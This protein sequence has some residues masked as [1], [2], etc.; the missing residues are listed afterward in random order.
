M[1]QCK[2]KSLRILPTQK[3]TGR[4]PVVYLFIGFLSGAIFGGSAVYLWSVQQPTQLQ[5]TQEESN[6]S[7][8]NAS[9]SES[10]SATS[11]SQDNGNDH[12][13]QPKDSELSKIFQHDSQQAQALN[14]E[15]TTIKNTSHTRLH[16]KEER[17]QHN[18]TVAFPMVTPSEEKA[19]S[20]T[21]VTTDNTPQASLHIAVTHSPFEVKENQ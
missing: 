15:H 16:H 19:T 11:T 5:V 12:I 3:K 17:T 10:G 20:P 9:S 2:P 21:D 6:S 18:T 13:L 8:A 4:K 14:T 1:T 7:T